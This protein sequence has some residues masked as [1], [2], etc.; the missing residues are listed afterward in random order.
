M[1]DVSL[2]AV[3]DV[4]IHDSGKFKYI[5]IKIWP[6]GDESNYKHIVRGYKW[7]GYHADIFDQW[8]PK[9]RL[10][11]ISCYCEGGG[12]IQHD[13]QN[14][15]ILVYGYSMGFG[16]ADHSITVEKLKSRYPNYASITFTNEGY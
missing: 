7:A 1:S 2:D 13:P 12:R 15:T 14:K 5:L 16:Q 6:E 4:D 8:E 3:E 11:K 10:Q 9:L